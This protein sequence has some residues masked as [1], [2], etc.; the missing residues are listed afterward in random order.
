MLESRSTV[1]AADG[2]EIASSLAKVKLGSGG[3]LDSCWKLES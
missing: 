2:L 1:D 3:T